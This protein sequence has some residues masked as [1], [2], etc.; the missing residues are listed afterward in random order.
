MANIL[1]K[2]NFTSVG[3]SGRIMDFVSVLSSSGDFNKVY[4]LDAII[5]SWK[6]ILTTPKGSMDH[7][8][9]FGSNLY[10]KIFDPADNTTKESIK[11]DIVQSLAVF[12][13]RAKIKDIKINFLKNSKGFNVDIVVNYQGSHTKISVPITDK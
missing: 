2:F 9:E 10:L 1:D 7:D 13:D 4:D 8:P 11:L 12:D 6:N 5:T 3:S